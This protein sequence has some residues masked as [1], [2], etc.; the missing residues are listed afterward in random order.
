MKLVMLIAITNAA[1]AQT[2]HLLSVNN[3]KKFSSQ[4]VFKFDALLKQSRPGADFSTFVLKA[5]PPDRRLCVYTVL[6]EYLSRTKPV[7]CKTNK[8]LL[9]YVKPYGPV[10]RDTV[11]R[12]IKTVMF[13]SGVNTDMFSAHSVRGASSSKAKLNAVPV[14][15]IL[16]KAGWSNCKTFSRFYDREVTETVSFEE[17][18]LK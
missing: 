13:R 17:G 14:S 18:V 2:I 8:L 11:S 16:E 3:M 4:F 9:S 15:A 5:Y 10:S 12:W 1:R 6:K 7:R